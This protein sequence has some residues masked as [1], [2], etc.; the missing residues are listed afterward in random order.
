MATHIVALEVSD[1]MYARVQQI[2]AERQRSVEAILQETLDLLFSPSTAPLPT[3]ETLQTYSDAQLW[4]V[5]HRRLLWADEMRLHEW[6]NRS[7][8]SP[9]SA[10]E[11]QILAH[12]VAQVDQTMVLRSQALTLL[13]QRGQDVATY[14]QLGA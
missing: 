2:A 6:M 13:Q 7:K 10:A 1:E 8:Q 12:L 4:A 3:V 5:V 14:L 11:T 9:L